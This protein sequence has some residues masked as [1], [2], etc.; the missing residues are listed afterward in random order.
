MHQVPTGQLA[1]QLRVRFGI[2]ECARRLLPVPV[3]LTLE[4]SE[5]PIEAR[6]INASLS[7]LY[8]LT[9]CTE[10]DRFEIG[11]HLGVAIDAHPE[12]ELAAF[13]SGAEVVRIDETMMAGTEAGAQAAYYVALRLDDELPL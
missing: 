3:H 8:M 9:E 5:D 10:C 1:T 13:A 12:F 2:A 4:D 6:G 11:M 7:G